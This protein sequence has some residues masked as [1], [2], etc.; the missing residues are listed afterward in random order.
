MVEKKE[1]T[2]K[3]KY[4]NKRERERINRKVKRRENEK[5]IKILLEREDRICW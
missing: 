3:E 2:K 5:E 4:Q 1:I